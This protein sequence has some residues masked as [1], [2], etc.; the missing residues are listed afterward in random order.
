MLY[1]VITRFPLD[2]IRS[3]ENSF[4]LVNQ[5]NVGFLNRIQ[6]YRITSY[7][8]CYTK[9]LRNMIRNRAGMPD[10]PIGEAGSELMDRYRNERR[11]ELS[12]EQHRY[13]DIRRWMIAEDVITPV[14]G[15]TIVYPYGSSTPT[16]TV[17]DG[18]QPRK[19][20]NK[21]YF[22]PILRDELNRNDQLIQN[23]GYIQ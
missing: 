10:V 7:N 21:S 5:D 9:L 19:W 15:I 13:F 12:Y 8:V 14:Q 20:E 6:S 16:Y 11:I 4:D 1:E 18:I 2:L 17:K 3:K 23:P 22:L